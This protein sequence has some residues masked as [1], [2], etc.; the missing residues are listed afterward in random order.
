MDFDKTISNLKENIITLKE[1]TTNDSE[2]QFIKDFILSIAYAK[3]MEVVSLDNWIYVKKGQNPNAIIHLNLDKKVRN[4]NIALSEDQS[5]MIT[6]NDI[7]Y[8]DSVLV[9]AE[10]L[11][12]SIYDFDVLITNN[13][14]Q[15]NASNYQSLHI[16]LRSNN[17]IN[18]NLRQSACIADEF[19]SLI[20]SKINTPVERYKPDYDHKI[21]RL[22]LSNLIGGHSGKDLDKHRLNAI[23][24][25][26]SF[27]RK[28]KAKVD[29]DIIKLQ[30]GE[31]Y[32]KIPDSGYIDFIIKADYESAL[33]ESYDLIKNE[34][35]E[36]NLK[37]EPDINLSLE[38]IYE[39]ELNPITQSS[40]EHLASFIELVPTGAFAVDSLTNELIS[41][42]NLSISRTTEESFNFIIIYRSLT[43]ESMKSMVEKTSIAAKI[44]SSSIKTGLVIPRW[45]NSNDTLTE[46]F[47]DSFK[48][49]TGDDLEVIK[50]QHSL[51]SSIIF[52]NLDVNLISLGVEYKQ[53]D[54]G[55]YYSLLEDI[56][57]VVK[58]IDNAIAHLANH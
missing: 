41:T 36:K 2:Y 31:R 51:D 38:E 14:I 23:K 25:L 17:I 56:L 16:H 50:T 52:N 15:L 45:K 55:N 33:F 37:Y 19:S 18:L 40:F 21:Y 5:H 28:V 48:Y 24:S 43:D 44:S 49:L 11:N 7:N 53:G 22:Y 3:A 30:A 27:I 10:M 29:L 57:T 26:V 58:V 35:M 4:P 32:E 42:M 8:I 47:K 34:Y 20:L 1:S 54:D 12:N 9:I 13:N 46:V 6:S 39:Y